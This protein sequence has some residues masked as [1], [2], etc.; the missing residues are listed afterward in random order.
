[1]IHELRDLLSIALLAL[2]LAACG[3][4]ASATAPAA[5]GAL[6]VDGVTMPISLYATL[7][8]SQQQRLESQGAHADWN[9]ADGKRQLNAIK[10]GA[11]RTLAFD[12]I[13]EHL[14]RADQLNVTDADV[15][16]GL[17]QVEQA[18]GGAPAFDAQLGRAGISRTDFATLFRYRLLEQKLRHA[19]GARYD[20]TI[21]RA[22]EAAKVQ[23]YVGPCQTDHAYPRCVG[24]G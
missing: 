4:P 8:R 23:A 19:E 17:A 10:A 9:S 15:A 5:T 18:V 3:A 7:V 21:K 11:I 2:A 24:G 16:A 1:M 13:I 14:A 20:A 12:A 22:V 6:I